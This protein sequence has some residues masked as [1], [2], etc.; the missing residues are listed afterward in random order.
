MPP[1]RVL[2]AVL[3]NEAERAVKIQAAEVRETKRRRGIS[4]KH[5][6]IVSTFTKL[7]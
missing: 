7:L 5:C 3:E 4:Y 2:F 6:H 1:N